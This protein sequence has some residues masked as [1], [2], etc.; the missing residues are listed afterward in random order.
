MAT[1]FENKISE[2]KKLV[3]KFDKIV[4]PV[5]RDPY[6]THPEFKKEYDIF[7]KFKETV[8]NIVPYLD[9]LYKSTKEKGINSQITDIIKKIQ[10]CVSS[11][12]V[13]N[14][15]L[16]TFV[17][18]TAE[19]SE[20]YKNLD[21]LVN[22]IGSTMSLAITEGMVLNSTSHVAKDSGLV[23]FSSPA[24]QSEI[25]LIDKF[26]FLEELGCEVSKRIHWGKED[27]VSISTTDP[28]LQLIL[29]KTAQ[30]Y[31]DAVNSQSMRKPH[32]YNNS[33]GKKSMD[34]LPVFNGV[35]IDENVGKKIARE[36]EKLSET[37][38]KLSWLSKTSGVEFGDKHDKKPRL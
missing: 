32:E 16:S 22:A 36:L 23:R 14:N 10:E 3:A 35:D 4:N 21:L 7:S 25:P 6:Y 9:E 11:V 5:G 37:K 27:G 31:G 34:Y 29:L 26:K 17:I 19:L 8:T 30:K 33:E 38:D 24:A 12:E 2:L 18:G 1:E 20:A 15:N 28:D 13:M